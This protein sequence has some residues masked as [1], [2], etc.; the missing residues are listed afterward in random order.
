MT[1]KDRR[2]A[3]AAERYA[4]SKLFKGQGYRLRLVGEVEFHEED[5]KH[6][7]VLKVEEDSDDII[8]YE[9]EWQ[10]VQFTHGSGL[11][12]PVLRV[13]NTDTG[14]WEYVVE[15]VEDETAPDDE[16]ITPTAWNDASRSTTP[17][18]KPILP[19]TFE[20]HRGKDLRI[21]I[22]VEKSSTKSMP[23]KYKDSSLAYLPEKTILLHVDDNGQRRVIDRIRVPAAQPVIDADEG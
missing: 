21:E 5:D 11:T 18:T 14:N 1:L 17:S 2:D 9:L 7:A 6:I 23:S 10:K 16:R 15:R 12:Y 8:N 22:V 4:V 13:L 19:G 20:N 3:W